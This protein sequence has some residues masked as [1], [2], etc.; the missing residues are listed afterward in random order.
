MAICLPSLGSWWDFSA[1]C[2]R[3]GPPSAT[4]L[5]AL[6]PVPLAGPPYG[7]IRWASLPD[8]A[9]IVDAVPMVVVLDSA[10]AASE[11]L[12]WSV[13]T[14]TMGSNSGRSAP[15]LNGGS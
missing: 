2:F 10:G 14:F 3:P 7:A 8:E 1:W 9:M 13:L 15:V 4:G 5:L 11:L 12:D 6:R